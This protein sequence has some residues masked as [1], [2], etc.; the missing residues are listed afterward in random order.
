MFIQAFEMFPLWAKQPRIWKC[1]ALHPN[2]FFPNGIMRWKRRL[3]PWRRSSRIWHRLANKLGYWLDLKLMLIFSLRIN[4]FGASGEVIGLATGT[5]VQYV[6]RATPSIEINGQRFGFM[7]INHCHIHW[8]C[9]VG[10]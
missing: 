3:A 5:R 1:F 2:Y 9:G 10:H 8:S 7:P 6:S 4:I